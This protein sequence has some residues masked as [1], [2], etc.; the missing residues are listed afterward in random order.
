MIEAISSP[1]THQAIAGNL[2]T[3]AQTACAV[4]SNGKAKKKKEYKNGR[5]SNH[6]IISDANLMMQL[7]GPKD[8]RELRRLNKPNTMNRRKQILAGSRNDFETRKKEKQKKLEN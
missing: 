3:E 4:G 2:E 7:R 6:E 5:T 1:D 8:R